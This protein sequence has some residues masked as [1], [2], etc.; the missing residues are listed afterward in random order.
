MKGGWYTRLQQHQS[1]R[2][3][4]VKLGYFWNVVLLKDNE[5]AATEATAGAAS[6]RVTC[7][8]TGV[9]E[10]SCVVRCGRAGD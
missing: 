2:R 3:P 5:L 8:D 6:E 1:D 4:V 9:V 7:P 10:I